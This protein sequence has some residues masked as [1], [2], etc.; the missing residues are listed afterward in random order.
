M[1]S[2]FR[3]VFCPTKEEKIEAVE[4]LEDLKGENK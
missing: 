1:M 3:K 2:S 4:M